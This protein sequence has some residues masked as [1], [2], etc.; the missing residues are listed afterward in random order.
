MIRRPPISTRTDTLCPY[1]T[2]FRSTALPRRSSHIA[3]EGA[4]MTEAQFGAI[5]V[6]DA[7]RGRRD[8]E[9]AMLD[10]GAEIIRPRARAT[11][12]L[13]G[14]AFAVVAAVIVRAQARRAVETEYEREED[15]DAIM[16]A[17]T[18]IA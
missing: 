7:V 9:V 16:P 3:V 1:T 13:V 17:R 12:S 6:I 11:I 18:F 15:A 4:E 2:L 14:Q 10:I 5:A 8:A